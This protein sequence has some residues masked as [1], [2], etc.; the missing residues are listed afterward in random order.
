MQ[1]ARPRNLSV[2]LHRHDLCVFTT[3]LTLAT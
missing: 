1:R 3:P 2:L